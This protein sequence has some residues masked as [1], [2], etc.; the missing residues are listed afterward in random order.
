MY[1]KSKTTP[2]IG[3]PKVICCTSSQVNN[4]PIR[5]FAADVF[6]WTLH[7]QKYFSSVWNRAK[8][9]TA[10][11]GGVVIFWSFWWVI[12][13]FLPHTIMLHNKKH[14]YGVLKACI[15]ANV[16]GII[17]SVLYRF[18]RSLNNCWWID[19][20]FFYA[21]ATH[22]KVISDSTNLTFLVVLPVT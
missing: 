21:R 2:T 13:Y 18:Q 16:S 20:I 4:Q 17:S 1:I 10:N 22:V 11:Y 7:V 3:P 8:G 9:S 19:Y 14:G 12:W 5:E 15:E 6:S